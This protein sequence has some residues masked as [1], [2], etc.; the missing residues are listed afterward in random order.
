MC[1][2]LLISKRF[3]KVSAVRVSHRSGCNIAFTALLV[4]L[5]KPSLSQIQVYF[6]LRQESGTAKFAVPIHNAT[7]HAFIGLISYSHL[8]SVH[9]LHNPII[10]KLAT[11]DYYPL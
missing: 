10:S 11:A 3:G 2:M 9:G 5:F 6:F 8:G 4:I 7:V 1:I